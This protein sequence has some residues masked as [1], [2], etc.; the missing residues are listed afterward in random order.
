MTQGGMGG[1]MLTN[2]HLRPE[3][4]GHDVVHN[5]GARQGIV[6]ILLVYI[7]PQA[8][9]AGGGDIHVCTAA[10]QISRPWMT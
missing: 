3:Q 7:Y 1:S 2:P 9:V 6:A 10:W 4:V 8:P 5:V